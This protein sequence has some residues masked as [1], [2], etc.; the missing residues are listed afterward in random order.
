[1]LKKSHY[2]EKMVVDKLAVLLA[3]SDLHDHR[4]RFLFA[5]NFVD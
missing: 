5:Y 1:M 4:D 2:V 3:Y